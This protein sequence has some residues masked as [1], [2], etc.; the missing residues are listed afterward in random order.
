MFQIA[1]FLLNFNTDVESVKNYA[2]IYGLFSCQML[3]A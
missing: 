2:Y 3:H 1:T